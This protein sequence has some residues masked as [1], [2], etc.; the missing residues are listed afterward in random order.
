MPQCPPP[1]NFS[2]KI[3]RTV[4]LPLRLLA[5]E[6]VLIRTL[7]S[8]LSAV[9]LAMPAFAQQSQPADR[10]WIATSNHYANM[11]IEV[12]FK[13]HPE[14]GTQQGSASSTPRFRSPR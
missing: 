1:A 10:S 8:L 2:L 4:L 3:M 6:D 14:A 9:V 7:L 13:Y 12:V 11:L 5:Q